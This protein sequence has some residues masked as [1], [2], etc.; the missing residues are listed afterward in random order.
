V[1]TLGLVKVNW[2]CPFDSVPVRAAPLSTTSDTVPVGVPPEELTVTV[3][4]AL[5]GYVT[6]GALIVVVVGAGLGTGA[7]A[8]ER[9][10][11]ALL[12]AKP[13]CAA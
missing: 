9:V 7:A 5:E 12:A 1:P 3:I 4:T 6:A 2:A 10:P 13:A 8:V 11:V